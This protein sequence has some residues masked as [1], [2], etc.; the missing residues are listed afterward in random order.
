MSWRGISKAG[1][2]VV[3]SLAIATAM[4]LTVESLGRW[5]RRGHML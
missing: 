3:L 2:A 5:A 4:D 1:P